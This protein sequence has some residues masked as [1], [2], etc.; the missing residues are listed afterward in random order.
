MLDSAL[1]AT[2]LM[3]S[4]HSTPHQD[5]TQNLVY[6][7]LTD[8]QMHTYFRPALLFPHSPRTVPL[9]VISH[10][11]SSLTATQR[12]LTPSLAGLLWH[13]W[14]SIRKYISLYNKSSLSPFTTFC[15][16]PG[17]DLWLHCF[18]PSAGYTVWHW[19]DALLLLVVN[20][21]LLSLQIHFSH[22]FSEQMS[23]IAKYLGGKWLGKAQLC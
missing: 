15:E 19:I 12:E 11:T 2:G 7:N 4:L 5:C 16:V 6:P 21:P 18:I 8:P 1:L 20:E 9:L 13:L 17:Q 14:A 22:F 3:H 10:L 23:L